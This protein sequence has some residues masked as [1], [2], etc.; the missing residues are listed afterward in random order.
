MGKVCRLRVML[1]LDM[2]DNNIGDSGAICLCQW[3]LAHRQEV[4]CRVLRLSRNAIGDDALEWLAQVSSSQDSAIE[5]LHLSHNHVTESGAIALLL[6]IATHPS[7]AYPCLNRNGLFAPAVINLD[8]NSICKPEALFAQLQT[9]V[10]LRACL[11]ETYT[12]CTRRYTACPHVHAP[13]LV[14]ADTLRKHAAHAA[15][16]ST[17]LFRRIEEVHS[18]GRR[19]PPA[20][21][22]V[23]ALSEQQLADTGGGTW[24]SMLRKQTHRCTLYVDEEFGAGLELEP[25]D[26]GLR[27]VEVF[28]YPGQTG[29]QSDDLIVAIDTWPLCARACPGDDEQN[30]RF[31]RHFRHGAC[32]DVQRCQR[33]RK[34]PTLG[35]TTMQRFR[36]PR[37]SEGFTTWQPCLRHLRETGHGP[38]LKSGARAE[39]PAAC[40]RRWMNDCV[41]AALSSVPSNL[42]QEQVEVELI[43]IPGLSEGRRCSSLLEALTAGAVRY[44]NEFGC[45]LWTWPTGFELRLLH[46]ASEGAPPSARAVTGLLE[47]LSFYLP[48]LEARQEHETADEIMGPADW[49][50]WLQG[51]LGQD[52]DVADAHHASITGASLNAAAPPFVP[53][54]IA[55]NIAGLR[56]VVLCGLPGSGKSTLAG[57]L[58]SRLG[59]SVVN[60][61]ALGSRQACMKMARACLKEKESCVVIDRCN[62]DVKQRSVWVQLAMHDFGF[63]ADALGCIWLDVSVDECEQRVMRRFGHST[64]PAQASSKPVIHGF[65]ESWQSPS[66]EEG[67]VRVWRMSSS[68]DMEMLWAELLVSSGHEH[69]VSE[70]PQQASPHLPLA[71]QQ[72]DACLSSVNQPEVIP[73]HDHPKHDDSLHVRETATAKRSINPVASYGSPLETTDAERA[74]HSSEHEIAAD[75]CVYVNETAAATRHVDPAASCNLLPEATNSERTAPRSDREIAA[76]RLPKQASPF[77]PLLACQQ[78]DDCLPLTSKHEV[79]PLHNRPQNNNCLDVREI[80]SATG[81]CEETVSCGSPPEAADHYG[82]ARSMDQSKLAPQAAPETQPCEFWR[83]P[84]ATLDISDDEDLDDLLPLNIKPQPADNLAVRVRLHAEAS[85]KIGKDSSN[86]EATGSQTGNVDTS[87]EPAKPD[88]TANFWRLPLP[89]LHD[90]PDECQN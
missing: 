77:H 10:G 71:C 56:V 17:D 85:S 49:T 90:D 27:V 11:E 28:D 87:T 32:L 36:C 29:L 9:H 20:I 38:P 47:V 82:G 63:G 15:S 62:V 31:G 70:L 5:V 4:R 65:A 18:G 51:M 72:K 21:V 74:A 57:E 3:L 2:S 84:L 69:A 89:E 53:R 79:I 86:A 46:T 44:C 42:Q 12:V 73:L 66:S 19:D 23:L 33:S 30:C 58:S 13:G 24:G 76:A 75:N 80:A 78:M 37:C 50:A 14:C 64:L 40:A 88:V 26:E 61:D 41:A 48:E 59:W 39:D 22:G 34:A 55:D 6:S 67:F 83:L 52:E 16:L 60:Q 81:P 1:E 35:K 7:E 25:V 43:G 8:G 45:V 68:V 54:S